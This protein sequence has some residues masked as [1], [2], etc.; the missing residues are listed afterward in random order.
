MKNSFR[1][2][3]R[4]IPQLYRTG[5]WDTTRYNHHNPESVNVKRIGARDHSASRFWSC[6]KA[7]QANF[8]AQEIAERHDALVVLDAR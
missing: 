7:G 8:G 1:G 4:A 5:A 6:C 3:V 2:I